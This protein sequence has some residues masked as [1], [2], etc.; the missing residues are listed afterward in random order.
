MSAR[1]VAAL[2]VRADSIPVDRLRELF[3]YDPATG[4]LTRRISISNGLAG[5]PAGTSNKTGHMTVGVDRKLVYVHRIAWAMQTGAWPVGEIDHIDGNPRN[6]R[7]ANLRDVDRATNMQNRRT[8]D[9]DSGTGLLVAF[10]AGTRFEAKI[11][12][13]G[14]LHRLGTFGTAAEAHEAYLVAK[15]RLHAGCAL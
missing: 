4:I 2:F 8:A 6:N 5:S 12:A 13:N 11:M 1:P 7:L 10:R 15:R 3:F 14:V 9:R